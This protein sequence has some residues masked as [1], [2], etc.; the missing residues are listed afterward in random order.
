MNH[1]S[2]LIAVNVYAQGKGMVNLSNDPV[3]Y[4]KK[5]RK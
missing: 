5:P 4:R 2:C 1:K 3:T